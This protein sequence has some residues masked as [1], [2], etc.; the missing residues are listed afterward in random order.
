VRRGK[1]ARRADAARRAAPAFETHQSA[2]FSFRYTP[3]DAATV[4]QTAARVE[5]ERA[6]I[7]RTWVFRP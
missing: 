3:I 4:A 2:N 1:P 6:R 5:A 7:S